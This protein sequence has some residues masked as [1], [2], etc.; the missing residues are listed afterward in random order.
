MAHEHHHEQAH[1]DPTE[2]WE[3]RYGES[4]QI[5]TGHVNK[6][7]ADVAGALEPGV[8]LDLGCGEG[9]DVI[10]LAQHGWR[11][12]GVDISTTAITRARAAALKLELGEQQA[13][14]LVEDL[15][16]LDVGGPFDLVTASFLQSPVELPRDEVLRRGADLVRVGG[17]LLITSHAAAPAGSGHDDSEFA[18]FQPDVQLASLGLPETEWETEVAEVR[19]RIGKRDDYEGEFLDSVVLL[20]RLA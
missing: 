7:L 1:Q 8:A 10:W 18:D 4:D 9:G 16:R 20:R 12:I 15:A 11:A 3:A 2:F 6:V 14:F 13:E 5:W 17:R 19:S